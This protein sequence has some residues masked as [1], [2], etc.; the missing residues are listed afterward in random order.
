MQTI[1]QEKITL[2]GAIDTGFLLASVRSV[3]SMSANSDFTELTFTNTF[4][5]YGLYVERGTGSNTP[6]GNGGDLGKPNNRKKKPWF[7]KKYWYS[8]MRMKEFM[9]ENMGDQFKNIMM[10]ALNY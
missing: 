9:E 3:G 10:T 4:T 6:K 2:L 1:W 5:E 7:S 8:S